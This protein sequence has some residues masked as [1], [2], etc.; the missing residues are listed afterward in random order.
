MITWRRLTEDD[1]PL[2][3]SWLERPHVARWWNHETSAEAVRRDFGPAVR[4][5]EPSE[6]LLAHLDGTPFG[7]M[8]RCRLADY[9]EYLVEVA[10]LIDVPSGAM[11]IDYLIGEPQLVGRGLGPRMIRSAVQA[12]WDEHPEASCVLVPVSAAN[13][14]SWRA[15]EKAG[16]QR[17]AEGELEPDNPVD[18]RAH[19]LYRV[20]RP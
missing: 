13:R 5:D 2:L 16:M 18:G 8:Q 3:M 15:L 6:E 17:V 10:T 19:Y 14:A 20:D 12:I 4:G 11:T 9:P 1:F 7:L